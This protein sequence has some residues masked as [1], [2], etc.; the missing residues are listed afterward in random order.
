MN[1]MTNN[2]FIQILSSVGV[3]YTKSY[4]NEIYLDQPYRN[5]FYGICQLLDK[6]SIW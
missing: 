4:A 1:I 5:T 2:I 6:Y 3:K